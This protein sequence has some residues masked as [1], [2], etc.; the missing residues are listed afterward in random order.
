MWPLILWASVSL[1]VVLQLPLLSWNTKFLR[2]TLLVTKYQ[3]LPRFH[4]YWKDTVNVHS[5]KFRQTKA[6]SGLSR[7]GYL[8]VRIWLWRLEALGAHIH[9]GTRTLQGAPGLTTRNKKLLVTKG[10]ATSNKDATSSS[11]P[12]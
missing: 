5:S 11:W 1:P 8:N 3:L 7:N 2:L 10:I 4:Q 12:Y 6:S 9:I